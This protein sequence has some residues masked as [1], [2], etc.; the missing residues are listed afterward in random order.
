MKEKESPLCYIDGHQSCH[1]KNMRSRNPKLPKYKARVVLRE[2]I[3]KDDSGAHTLFTEQCSSVSQLTAAKVMDVLVRLPRCAGQA[4]DAVSAYTQVKM[5]DAPKLLNFPKSEC[6]DILVRLP[7]HKWP[8]SWSN[9]EDPV[10]LSNEI[11][12]DTHLQASCWKDSSTK[13][14]WDLDGKKCRIGN[15]F[16]FIGNKDC[17]SR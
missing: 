15:V 11:C 5:E 9:I 7:R 10:V 6:P 13:L 2:D 3:V 17:S 12:T 16:L 4:A 8:K 14:C 1:V